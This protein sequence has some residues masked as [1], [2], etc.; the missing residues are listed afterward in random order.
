MRR[1][2]GWITLAGIGLELTVLACALRV[3]GRRTGHGEVSNHPEQSVRDN[4]RAVEGRAETARASTSSAILREPQDDKATPLQFL[5]Q[6][7]DGTTTKLYRASD[8]SGL[9]L[10]AAILTDGRVRIA[11]DRAHCF[12]GMIENGRADLLDVANNEWSE[13][14]LH[15]SPNGQTQ[16]EL[17]GGPYDAHVLTVRPFDTAQGDI[18]Y[19]V[20]QGDKES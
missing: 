6:N 12:A 8:D 15:V 7:A 5:T 13:L 11:D 2:P 4:E 18:L 14:F 1:S 19:D 3:M 17:R 9:E 20:A 10:L 16:F